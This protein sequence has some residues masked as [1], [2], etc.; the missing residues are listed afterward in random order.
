MKDEETRT[1]KIQMKTSIGP[2]YGFLS[3]QMASGKITGELD[4]LKH[5][6][7]FEGKTDEM[8]N[9]EFS[10]QILTLMWT[11][12][13]TATGVITDD[14]VDLALKSE[15]GNFHITGEKYDR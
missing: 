15:Q 14:T 13:Y 4:I 12:K 10:G 11:I 8:G 9:C 2:R 6:E 3:C 7:P 1:Y 5:I